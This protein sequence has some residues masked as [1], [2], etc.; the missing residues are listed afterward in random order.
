MTGTIKLRRDTR[1]NWNSNDP[2]LSD[3]EAGFEIDT[4]VVRVGDGAHNFT[5]LKPVGTFVPF[6]A[7]LRND[8]IINYYFG[9]LQKCTVTSSTTF[10]VV[11]GEEG[12]KIEVWVKNTGGSAVVVDFSYPP[13][14]SSNPTW[15]IPAGKTAIFSFRHLGIHFVWV[16]AVGNY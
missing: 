15:N 9:P 6:D 4:N 2:T 3:G 13:S 11:D 7:G 5:N 16:A 10:S 14:E 1:V 12:D 8:G